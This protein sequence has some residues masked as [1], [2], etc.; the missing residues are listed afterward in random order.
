[1]LDQFESIVQ[2]AQIVAGDRGTP[3]QRLAEGFRAFR[4]ATRSSGDWPAPLWE[5]YDEICHLLLARG[6]WQKTLDGMDAETANECAA[7]VSH[8]M[9]DLATAV[10]LART[11]AMIHP[12]RAVGRPTSD[13]SASF[14]SSP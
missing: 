8:A 11:D 14:R 12:R 3:Q 13:L 9:N 6:S 5:K 4:R 2:A 1:M 10:E 7:R